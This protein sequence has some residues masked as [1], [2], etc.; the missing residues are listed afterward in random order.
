MN[1]DDIKRAREIIAAFKDK[2][3]YA[4][5]LFG[6]AAHKG[7]PEALDDNDKLRAENER[8]QSAFRV[9]EFELAQRDM[10]IGKLR[11]F[12]EEIYLNASGG[13][14][15]AWN[16]ELSWYRCQLHGVIGRA[17]RFAE[18]WRGK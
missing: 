1:T 15:A 4:N 10:E 9:H 8:L 7:W 14:P 5:A 17:A 12:I 3:G 2:G 11:E 6:E 18:A 16:D 13:M